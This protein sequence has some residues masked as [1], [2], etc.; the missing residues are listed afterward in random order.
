LGSK[1]EQLQ[2]ENTAL[3]YGIPL[4]PTKYHFSQNEMGLFPLPNTK[5]GLEPLYPIRLYNQTLSSSQT[6]TLERGYFIRLNRA[7]PVKSEA[8]FEKHS[9][10]KLLIYYIGI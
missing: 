9:N 6:I 2:K 7:V 4:L 3:I 1:T 8:L 5:I 10:I